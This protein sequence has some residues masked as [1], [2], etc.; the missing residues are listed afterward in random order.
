MARSQASLTSRR[1]ASPPTRA[2]PSEPS[3]FFTVCGCQLPPLAVAIP[4][5]LSASAI[6]ASVPIPL[7]TMPATIGAMPGRNPPPSP[8]AAG[9]ITAAG[10]PRAARAASSTTIDAQVH[11]YERNLPGR[12]SGRAGGDD[13]RPDGGCNGC[14]RCRRCGAGVAVLD[15]SLRPV[16]RPRSA[17]KA[18][19][20]VLPSQTG[21]SE[22]PCRCRHHRRLEGEEGYGRRPRH[23][24]R[25]RRDRPSH[26]GIN[27]V[28]RRRR[29]I[30]WR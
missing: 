5:A 6:P 1:T 13:G 16:L 3:T 7:A 2:A 22:R 21:R 15:V 25:Q 10:L 9:L 8:A 24:A 12:H 19:G 18:P 23:H 30:H 11:A 14:G 26:P 4:R 29:S 20:P 17:G 28:W 27:R